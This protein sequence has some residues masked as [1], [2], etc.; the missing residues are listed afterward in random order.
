MTAR[1]DQ[2][3]PAAH[4]GIAPKAQKGMPKVDTA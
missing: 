2:H 3:A 4:N 1:T